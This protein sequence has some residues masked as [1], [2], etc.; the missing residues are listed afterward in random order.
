MPEYF[1]YLQTRE[2]NSLQPKRII[3]NHV[4]VLRANAKGNPKRNWKRNRTVVIA[5]DRIKRIF[6]AFLPKRSKN[7]LIVDGKGKFLIPGMVDMHMHRDCGG[8]KVELLYLIN[9]ITAYRDMDGYVDLK[10][11]RDPIRANK[12]LWPDYYAARPI[13]RRISAPEGRAALSQR[14][15]FYTL[16]QNVLPNQLETSI[17]QAKE[18]RVP[19][20]L[21]PRIDLPFG[22]LLASKQ[23]K[24]LEKIEGLM[25]IGTGRKGI[26]PAEYDE[27]VKQ[28]IFIVPCLLDIPMKLSSFAKGYA[29]LDEKDYISEADF[30]RWKLFYTDHSFDRAAFFD[31]LIQIRSQK[32]WV[33]QEFLKRNAK[34]LIGTE[35]GPH[36]APLSVPGFSYSREMEALHLMGMTQ[37]NVLDAATKNA[38]EALGQKKEFGRVK[39]GLRADL[40]LLNADPLEELH[41]IRDIEGVLLRGVWLDKDE[42]TE[43]KSFAKKIY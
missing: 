11:L 27:I 6:P 30:E 24:T 18:A 22:P 34:I 29:E 3:Y 17:S 1:E 43:M 14:P 21:E 15:D 38:A 23:V 8:N 13:S 39:K 36:F 10:S 37:R 42:L 20:A 19:I 26:S 28:K 32:S 9:G 41:A 40:V 16:G 31:D 4:N 25:S 5:G 35:T 12:I 2:C 7:A 33:M